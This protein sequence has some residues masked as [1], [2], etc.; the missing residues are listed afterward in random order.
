MT[1]SPDSLLTRGMV[2]VLAVLTQQERLMLS[3][4]MA[5]GKQLN[6]RNRE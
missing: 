4:G 1:L 2:L 6:Q 5:T 3:I